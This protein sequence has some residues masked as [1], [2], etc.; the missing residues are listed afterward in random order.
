MT[1]DSF[2]QA[3]GRSR[4]QSTDGDIQCGGESY[5]LVQ[6]LG[7]GEISDVYLARRCGPHPL[8]AT[9]KISSSPAAH[10]LY[11]REAKILREL[12]ESLSGADAANL[13]VSLPV[14]IR[15][16]AVERD[17]GRQALI[18]HHPN[19]YW[20]SL[21]A[22]HRRFPQGIDPRHAVWIWR[23]I[24]NILHAVHSQGWSHGDVC[25]E[26]ALV[27]PADHGVRLISWA[28]ATKGASVQ[29]KAADLKRAALVVRV[30]LCGASDAMPATAPQGLADLLRNTWDDVG[31]CLKYGAHGLDELLQSEA[32]KAFGPPSFVPLIL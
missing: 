26:H 7:H 4:A 25:P 24:L 17:G 8:L 3:L 6:S 14:V 9:V 15:Q 19:G 1:R 28:S 31:F 22:L 12:H 5:H 29:Q 23:R 27:H 10:E 30:L 11:S 20:G 2:R 32:R 21:A 18:L 16:G 13:S